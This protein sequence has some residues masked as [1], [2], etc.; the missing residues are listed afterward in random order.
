ME[1]GDDAGV[2]T[3]FQ[4][5]LR[6]RDRLDGARDARAYEVSLP[7]VDHFTTEFTPVKV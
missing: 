2:C 7:L 3:P 4:G 5:R 1:S 6:Q